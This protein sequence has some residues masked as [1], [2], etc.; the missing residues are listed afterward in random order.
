MAC[1]VPHLEEIT[2][3][4]QPA[5]QFWKLWR[6]K[7]LIE[8][9]A[10]VGEYLISKLKKVAGIK[11]VRGLGLMIGLEFDQQINDIRHVLLKKTSYFYR[12]KRS[13]TPLGYFLH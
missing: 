4:V 11:E 5:W 9:A 2:W 12:R 8:N 1:W 7:K 10:E 3:L 13:K 6:T